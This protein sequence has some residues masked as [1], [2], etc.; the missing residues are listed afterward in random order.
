MQ[1]GISRFTQIGDWIFEVKMVRALRVENYGE[2][3]DAVATLTA[4][5]ESMYI[6]TQLTRQHN[7][8]SREDCMAFYEFAKQ[9]E[10]KQLQY[11]KLR[12]VERHSRNVEIVENQRP[13]AVVQLVN[14]NRFR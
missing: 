5:G 10:M 2:P 8:L 6:D 1:S 7:E 13:R 9:L 11:D 14:G 3:Y 12:N 4:N